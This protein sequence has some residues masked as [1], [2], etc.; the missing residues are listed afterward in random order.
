MWEDLLPKVKHL[1]KLND[2]PVYLILHCGAND[3]GNVENGY[4]TKTLIQDMKLVLDKIRC[5][6]PE[7]KIVWSQLL[8]RKEWRYSEDV[9]AMNRSLGRINNAVASDVIRKGGCYIKYPDIKE[10]KADLFDDDNVHLSQAGNEILL[11]NMSAAIEQFYT[12]GT[13]VYPKMY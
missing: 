9:D 3:V 1:M 4:D 10:S 7:V 5:L 11:N 2:P 6:M 13:Q 12:M 8:P